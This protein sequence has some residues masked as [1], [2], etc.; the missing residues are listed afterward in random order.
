MYTL[1]HRTTGMLAALLLACLLPAV[2]G[3]AADPPLSA[4]PIPL[5][6][7]IDD[8]VVDR[9]AAIALGKALFW[10]MQLGSDG[11]ACA[12][13]HFQAGGDNRIKNQISPGLLNQTVDTT[14]EA[15]AGANEVVTAAAYP[16]HQRVAP[17][18]EQGSNVL[19][20]FKDVTSSQGVY[21]T[22]FV[23][24]IL[25]SPIDAG[26]P[27]ADPVFNVGG[28]NVRRVE[29]RNTP[30][31]I[32]A[33]FF[34][35][36]FW[37]GRASN[38]FNG[39]N[40]FGAADQN[41]KVFVD[42][43]SG[44]AQELFRM[45]PASL[46]SQA[47][48][49]PLSDFEMSFAGRSFQKL[50]KKMLSLTPL[51]IQKVHPN[52]SVL[53]AMS[54]SPND[55]LNTSYAAMIMAAFNSRYWDNTT[56]HVELVGGVPTIVPGA[57][58]PGDTDEFTQ[59]EANFA[60]LFGTSVMLY[61]ATLVSDQAPIDAFLAGDNN[62]LSDAAKAGMSTFDGAGHCD[63]CHAGTLFTNA[64]VNPEGAGIPPDP[65]EVETLIE[66]MNMAEGV[67]F[68]DNGFYNISVTPTAEDIGRGGTTPFVNPITN[69][70]FPLSFSRMAMLKA[71][72]LLPA[73]VAAFVPDLPD[74]NLFLP[75]VVVPPIPAPPDL[76]PFDPVLPPM[77][78]MPPMPEK[79]LVAQERLA[80][81][82]ALFDEKIAN[83][84][85]NG[86]AK[87]AAKLTATRTKTAAKQQTKIDK[88]ITKLA[89]GAGTYQAA[90]AAWTA[91]VNAAM[92]QAQAAGE[93]A[94]AAWIAAQQQAALEA[95][96]AQ[97]RAD[98]ANMERVAV[99]GAFKVPS[100][101]NI[102][103]TG[104]Y[105]HDGSMATLRQ[106][107]EFYTRGGNHP[108]LNILN[109]DPDIEEIGKLRGDD[110]KK[111]EVVAFLLSLTDERVAQEMAPFDHPELRIPHGSIPNNGD[112]SDDII[113]VLP[114]VGAAG[115]PAESLP[116][117]GT[118]LNLVQTTP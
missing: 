93:A 82:L 96:I 57:A 55:G 80:D 94:L 25:G 74:A 81:K 83:A 15:V 1:T 118:F 95:A 51:G 58:D 60:L 73:D 88:L 113:D 89:P 102:E 36:N 7:N 10:D 31:M 11:Q 22:Q 56:Q 38:V 63:S 2:A 43:G 115:R 66:L 101:R 91:A 50:G 28:I 42:D 86:N 52:D 85:L 92:A 24:I 29:P 44:L 14:F 107:V 68:Y 109:L 26:A 65:A 70:P 13:C 114:A 4:V 21:F 77:P 112:F 97:A 108:A 53:G 20:D 5:P 75:D 116:R 33:V 17:V 12:S 99:D 48:G 19:R 87:Q 30:T 37:D 23:D 69:A 32:N 61:E 84:L 67:A 45:T 111:D 47:V 54:N 49:P 39:N 106:V 35:D 64:L 90:M 16:F 34:I 9:A 18:D 6:A 78:V 79:I 100:L 105:M 41:S 104:P 76:G 59:M 71:A 62:A 103:L 3:R 40:P 46:A 98:I 27:V 110:D 72:G 8:I 117:M